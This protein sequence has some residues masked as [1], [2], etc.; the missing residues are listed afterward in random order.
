MVVQRGLSRDY[1]SVEVTLSAAM[2]IGI[3]TQIG[4]ICEVHSRWHLAKKGRIRV[5]TRIRIVTSEHSAIANL[6]LTMQA[7][8]T[9]IDLELIN[10]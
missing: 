10:L 1:V 8:K 9:M 7:P 4:C 3:T 2:N 5:N 6:M